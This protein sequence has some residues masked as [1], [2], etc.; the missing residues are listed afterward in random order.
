MLSKKNRTIRQH[1][2]SATMSMK[3]KLTI[4]TKLEHLKR[5]IRKQWLI[6]TLA[7]LKYHNYHSVK[8][9]NPLNIDHQFAFECCQ[10]IWFIL[11]SHFIVYRIQR[12]E[13]QLSRCGRVVKAVDQKSTW[14]SRAGSN[15]ADDVFYKQFL[16]SNS[17]SITIFC[18]K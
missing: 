4:I 10:K 18:S 3:E 12:Q 5:N 14:F 17:V 6:K 15:P 9:S 13:S 1:R 8:P 11:L 2:K 16:L 7:K